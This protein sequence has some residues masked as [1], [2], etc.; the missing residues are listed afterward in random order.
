MRYQEG[1]VVLVPFTWKDAE[2]LIHCKNRPAVV[3]RVESESE[4]LMI[5]C[6]HVNHSQQFTGNGS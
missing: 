5:K 6:T 3:Y 1:D 2:G 4:H